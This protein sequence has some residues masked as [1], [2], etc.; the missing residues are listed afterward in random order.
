MRVLTGTSGFSYKAW[1]GPFYPEDLKNDAM[2]AYYSARL[3][4]VEMNNTFYRL[5]KATT[6]EKWAATVPDGFEFSLKAS[7]R[8]THVKRLKEEVA[9]TVD[10]LLST[11]RSMGDKLGPILFQLPP[12]AK[13]NRERLARFLKLLP[14]DIKAAFEFRHESW[15]DETVFDLLRDHGA[16]L[17]IADMGENEPAMVATADWGYL[18]LRRE[19][20]GDEALAVWVERIH[21]QPWKNAYVFF[22]HEEAGAGPR[23]ATQLAEMLQ[24]SLNVSTGSSS[25]S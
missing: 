4:A 3:R 15:F 16:A 25:S 22:K 8:I 18:R 21:A 23:L 13:V 20:Y 14:A 17:C 12:N 19:G 9:D 6:V 5:P 7:R 24:L 11:A 2:L 10:Y 1:K